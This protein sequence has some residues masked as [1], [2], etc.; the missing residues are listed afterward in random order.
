M[1]R[2]SVEQRS[3]RLSEGPRAAPRPAVRGGSRIVAARALRRAGP[4]QHLLPFAAVL[5]FLWTWAK[6]AAAWIE[7]EVRGY[8]ATVTVPAGGPAEARH[9]LLLKVRGGP[10]QSLEIEGVGSELELLG[11]GTV[12]SATN[13]ALPLWPLDLEVSEAGNLTLRIGVE[14]GL[15]SGVYRFEF[16]YRFDA[17]QRGWLERRANQ[18]RITWVQPR[19]ASGIDS[20]RVLF[21]V[22]RGLR[23]PRLPEEEG[24]ASSVLLSEV[25]R[26][27]D[28]DEVD[29][30]RAHVAKQEPAVWQ[31]MVPAET[32]PSLLAPE[33]PPAQVRPL[34]PRRPAAF[35]LPTTSWWIWVVAGV[36]SLGYGAVL[37]LKW[38]AVRRACAD[39]GAFPR[40]VVPLPPAVRLPLSALALGAAGALALIEW[41]AAAG[42]Y[43]A[44]ALLGAASLP[45]LRVAKARGPGEWVQLSDEERSRPPRRRSPGRWLDAG[46]PSGAASLAVLVVLTVGSSWWLLPR[47]P[48]HAGLTLA[49]VVV[50]LPVFLTG[51]A[52]DM[53]ADPAWGS[54]PLYGWLAGKLARQAGVK[55]E[56][57]GRRP[58]QTLERS[59][60]PLGDGR[61]SDGPPARPYDEIRMRL[62][63]PRALAGLRAL[64]IGVEIGGGLTAMPCVVVRVDDDSAAYR[65]LPRS[66]QWVRGRHGDERVA[67]L[68]PRVPSRSQ[69]LRVALGALRL[70]AV[71][72]DRAAQRPETWG[73]ATG[74]GTVGQART[75]V[76][77]M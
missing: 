16:G 34:E 8:Q 1:Q 60:E 54:L 17:R 43:L 42:M 7:T 72:G 31:V 29:L 24:P 20:A 75:A 48:Y 69:C 56:Y 62:C 33:S 5:C 66:V 23:E 25:R 38:R 35:A 73:T 57:W 70:L 52:A 19:F 44:A 37:G 10:L 45:P 47:S 50:W 77:P 18:V 74:G 40:G 65:A 76:A 12:R 13:S 61:I 22:P 6:P 49:S 64:E 39:A 58:L 3:V 67:I 71:P 63:A 11:D 26:G 55:V 53:P 41:P 4:R 2:P 15:R 68:R 46:T 28:F 30:I 59:A 51:R 32:F 27:P 14:R 21:R 9:E 36:L